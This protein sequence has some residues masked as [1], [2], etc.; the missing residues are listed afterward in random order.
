LL[1]VL[2]GAFVP[3]VGVALTI[4]TSYVLLRKHLANLAPTVFSQVPESL[5]EYV[6]E[7]YL[8]E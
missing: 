2:E 3:V 8:H 5:A 1:A 7:R 6:P 4:A